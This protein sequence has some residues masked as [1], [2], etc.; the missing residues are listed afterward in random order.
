MSGAGARVTVVVAATDARATVGVSLARFAEEVRGLGDV[1]L[2]DASRD[3]TADEVERALPGGVRVLRRAPGALAPELWRDGLEASE[4]PLVAF[5]TA[6][7]VPQPGWLGALVERLEAT[8]AAAVGGP[9]EP[10]GALGPVGRAVYL[11]RHVKY[12]RPVREDARIEPPGDNAL[13]RRDRLDEV[14]SAWAGGFWE[15]EVH[16]ALLSRGER[17]AMAHDA[18]VTYHG[19]ARLGGLVRQRLRHARRYGADRSSRIGLAERLARTAAAPAVPWV[20]GCR[21][22]SALLVRGR[23][24]GPWVLAFP[25]LALLLAAWATGEALGVCGGRRCSRIRSVAGSAQA[26]TV[27]DRPCSGWVDGRRVGQRA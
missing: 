13:Y 26:R 21:A 11:A 24:I 17:L 27:R 16:R 4:T 7:M 10:A 9:I 14:R 20:M 12:L 22:L 19:G 15:A 25:A 18:A 1:L 8:G 3:G 2:M 5:T 6:V 23:A